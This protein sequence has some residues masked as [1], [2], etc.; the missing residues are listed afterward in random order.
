MVREQVNGMLDKGPSTFAG[1]FQVVRV[2]AADLLGVSTS[3]Q[4]QSLMNSVGVPGRPLVEV[5]GFM[6]Q[7]GGVAVLQAVESCRICCFT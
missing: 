5:A 4:C 2:H 7:S 3:P 1:Y 6:S